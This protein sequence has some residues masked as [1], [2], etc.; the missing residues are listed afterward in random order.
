MAGMTMAGMREL[1]IPG[2]S[3]RRTVAEIRSFL[4]LSGGI[5]SVA[6]IALTPVLNFD[7]L[8]RTLLPLAGLTLI[9]NPMGLD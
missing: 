7:P 9:I 4:L 1:A 3:R 6:L 5:A 2:H 8:T